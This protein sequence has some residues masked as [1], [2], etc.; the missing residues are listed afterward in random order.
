MD[1]APDG[2]VQWRESITP[3]LHSRGVIVYDPTKKPIDIGWER[4]ENRD[5]RRQLKEDGQYDQLK[6]EMKPVRCTDLRMVDITDFLIVNL[7]MSIYTTGTHEEITTANRSKKPV[8]IRCQQGKNSVPDWLFGMLPHE[9]F[10]QEWEQVYE[11]L[12][13]IDREGRNDGRWYF[14][15]PFIPSEALS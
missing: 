10:F 9:T 8:I 7:D 1:L 12:D 6:A 15:N 11:Y 5:Y 13:L 4:I 2:G 14:F 3:W